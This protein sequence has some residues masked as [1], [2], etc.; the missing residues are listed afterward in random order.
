MMDSTSEFDYEALARHLSGESTPE[1]SA[2]VESLLSSTPAAR[3]IPAILEKTTA[4][5]R[6]D[7]RDLDVESALA[8]VKAR[9]NSTPVIPLAAS[10]GREITEQTPM[11]R[12]RVPM[13]ALAAVALL[14]VGVASWMAY[15]NRPIETASSMAAPR[16]LATGVGARDSMTLS[17]GTRVILGPLSSITIESGYNARS[18][19]VQV[20]GD[21]WFSVVHDESKPFTVHAGN[22]TIVDVG[23]TFT[24]ASDS[25]AGVAV[26]VAEG[27]VSL[28]Q[29]NGRPGHGV[30]LKAGDKGLLQAGGEPVAQRGAA[31]EDDAAWLKGRLVFREATVAE[32]ASSVRKWYGIELKVADPSLANRHLTAT[33]AGESP[34]RVLDIIRL[35]LGAEIERRGDTAIVRESKGSMHIR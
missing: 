24:V 4:V 7:I 35:A 14:A 10:R 6:S 23:T 25:P 13:P 16:M 5:L 8:R 9:R 31:T 17:D 26:S 21:A 30:I 27:S 28:Q 18:R 1:E 15:R 19:N 34:D 20:R 11:R 12:W 3:A 29:V 32:I 22:A 33:F 2:H